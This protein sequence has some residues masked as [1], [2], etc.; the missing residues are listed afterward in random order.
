M[1]LT[2]DFDPFDAH[3]KIDQEMKK[4]RDEIRQL[5]NK[6]QYDEAE[7]RSYEEL[8]P[9]HEKWLTSLNQAF[10]NLRDHPNS[11]QPK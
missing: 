9:L 1:I 10:K 2:S 4:L 11:Y 8:Q 3:N 7:R 5:C 6:G